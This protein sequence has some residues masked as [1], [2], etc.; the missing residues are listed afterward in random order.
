MKVL[1]TAGPTQEPIDDIRYITNASSGKFGA[2]LAIEGM[3]RGHQVTLIHGPVQIPLPDCK[4]IPFRT[5][6]EMH[7]ILINELKR[8]YDIFI[9]TAAVSDFSP[10]KVCGKIKSGKCLSI[11][12]NPTPKIIDEARKA[13]PD[14]FIIGFKAEYGLSKEELRAVAK[15]F[16]KEKKLDLVVA[17]DI[18]KNQFGAEETEVFVA[19]KDA[20][21]DFGKKSKSELAGLIWA[22]IELRMTNSCPA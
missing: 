7:D 6:K 16:L 9:A 4:K 20:V 5:A 2:A 18:E 17:N 11:I 21:K 12:L 13:F 15:N 1:I 8:S 3:A 10:E 22:E 19:S 14:L